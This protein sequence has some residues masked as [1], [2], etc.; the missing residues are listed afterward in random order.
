MCGFYGTNQI[1]KFS[2]GDAQ[3]LEADRLMALRG[4]DDCQVF[5]KNNIFLKHFRLITRGSSDKGKQPFIGRRYILLFNGNIINSSALAK[6]YFIDDS[7]SDTEVLSNLLEKYGIKIISELNGF[8][9]IV[10]FDT[11]YHEWTLARDRLGIKPLF[12]SAELDSLSFSSRADV[13]AKLLQKNIDKEKLLTTLKYGSVF[14]NETIYKNIEQVPPGE[15]IRW[16]INQRITKETFWS[17]DDLL[18]KRK[19]K[20][21]QDE[22]NYLIKNSVELNLITKRDCGI[23]FS[24]GVDSLAVTFAYQNII[25]NN[26]RLY[27]FN[28]TNFQSDEI[29][30]LGKTLFVNNYLTNPPSEDINY[31][32]DV[33]DLPFDDTSTNLCLQI[34]KQATSKVAVCLTGDG[35]DEIF[36]GYSCFK[37]SSRLNIDNKIFKN[38][39]EL[40]L[41]EKFIDKTSIKNRRF[42]QLF[43]P[44]DKLLDSLISNCFKEWEIMPLLNLKGKEILNSR[45]K[46]FNLDDHYLVEDKI[47]KLFIKQKLPNQMFYKVDRSS[48]HYGIESRPPLVENEILD[49]ALKRSL[50]END[51]KSKEAIKNYNIMMSNNDKIIKR[52]M[53]GKKRGFGCPSS[54]LRNPLKKEINAVAEYLND[55][56]N[57]DNFINYK[58]TNKRQSQMIKSIYNLIS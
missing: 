18:S 3:E 15:I 49:Y 44:L 36:G 47:K 45:I 42:I 26:Q 13:L 46:E 22:I 33:F 43:L 11:L 55:F 54:F 12:F 52:L 5:Q 28:I 24:G 32:N 27:G 48:M 35:A 31:E 14:I 38:L 21:N 2:L 53:R 6:K 1:S 19:E 10:V 7:E 56:L 39:K 37:N 41:N 23:L 16:K 20:N 30:K 9:A 57:H 58:W 29:M 51:F 17:V 8:F 50:K 40:I 25:Q 4:P 34:Y